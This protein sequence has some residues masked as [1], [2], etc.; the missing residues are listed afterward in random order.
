MDVSRRGLLLGGLGVV[1]LGAASA[2]AAT[3]IT[4]GASDEPGAAP[5]GRSSSG[6]ASPTSTG[7][8]SASPNA[9]EDLDLHV[10]G[11]VHRPLSKNTD[12]TLTVIDGALAAGLS[13]TGTAL[14]GR[15]TATG[16]YAFTI[17]VRRGDDR[18]RRR[19]AGTVGAITRDLSISLSLDDKTPLSV[20][21]R[22]LDRIARLGAHATLVVLCYIP[23]ATSTT[24]TRVS[25][26]RIR[27]VFALA[28]DRGVRITLLKPHIAT[29]QDGDGFYRAN[30]APSSVDGFFS[31][32]TEQMVHFAGLCADNDIE[33]LS[34]ACEQPGQTDA[35]LYAK[36]VDLVETVRSVEP[37][38]NLTAAFTTLELYLLHT[39]WLPQGTP[40]M[41]QLLDVF[42]INSWI[43]LTD[44]VYTPSAPNISVDE[45]AA[46]W[47]G[48]GGRTD[49]HLGKLEDVCQRLQMPFL[50]TEVGVQPR[51]DGLAQQEGSAPPTGAANHDV[52]ALLYRSI[53]KAPLTSSWCT[54]ASIWHMRAPFAFG[55]VYHDTLFAGEKVLKDAIAKT[56]SLAAPAT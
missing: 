13:I 52:Q 46:G 32:W 18:R 30:Y 3:V 26:D 29:E 31:R 42:G 25:D 9:P 10:W 1:A 5:S 53:L 20:T 47:R 49:D 4:A 27:K 28:K 41:A 50:I 16:D 45:L 51:V 54:G 36:W 55:D 14:A 35:A 34:I 43:R 22:E 11:T 24:F 37:A 23:D 33:Y 39:Y 7:S 17:E 40:H 48:A 38:V 6:T 19:F 12:A 56:P 2:A 15:L 44:K 8:A 21:A